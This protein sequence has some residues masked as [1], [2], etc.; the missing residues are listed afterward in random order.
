MNKDKNYKIKKTKM[1]I[2]IEN[3]VRNQEK[4]IKRCVEGWKRLN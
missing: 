1:K 2:D 3:Y 4:A